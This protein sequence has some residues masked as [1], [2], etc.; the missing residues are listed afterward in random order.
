M[1]SQDFSKNLFPLALV[2][3]LLLFSSAEAHVTYGFYNDTCPHAEAIVIR[4]MAKV[5]AKSPRLAGPLLRMHFVDC[6]VAGC[7]ASILL[8]ST[9]KYV[10]EKDAPLNIGLR[11]FDVIDAIKVKLEKTC[12]GIV[13]CADII[14]MVARDSVFL[15]QGPYYEIPLGRRDGNRSLASDTLGNLPP[16]DSNITL[17]KAF[18]TKRNMTVKDMVVLSGSHTIGISH[19]LSFSDRLYNFTGKGDMDPT[20]DKK[21]A[22]MLKSLCKPHDL[23]SAVDMDPGSSGRFDLRYY[24]L[25]SKRKGLFVSDAALLHDSETKAYVE[26]QAKAKTAEEFFHDFAVSMI[27][28]GKIGV[29]THQKGVIRKNCAFVN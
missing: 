17:L 13:S 18:F 15:S 14:A 21:Y 12:P 24:K 25:V 1:V 23:M 16:P 27:N 19:C 4:E 20:L 5:M 22:T 10:A 11:G 7:E 2:L 28:M 26:R 3:L 9:E 29:L 8:N 6:F